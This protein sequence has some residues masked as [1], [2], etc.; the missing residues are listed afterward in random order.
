MKPNQSRALAVALLLAA[1]SV[2]L[3]VAQSQQKQKPQPAQQQPPAGQQPQQQPAAQTDEDAPKTAFNGQVTMSGSRNNKDT[4]SLGFKGMDPD[5]KVTTA[6][7]NASPTTADT[8]AALQLSLVGVSDADLQAFIKD[9]KL[10]PG[11]PKAR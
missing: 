2:A 4:A 1:S 9:G 11:K 7:L 8:N 3:A 6:A 5:G 10:N